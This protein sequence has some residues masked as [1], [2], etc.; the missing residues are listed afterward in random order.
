MGVVVVVDELLVGLCCLDGVQVYALDV[1]DK[2]PF[3]HGLI[4]DIVEN[5]SLDSFESRK[6][7]CPGASF[8]ADNLVAAVHAPYADGL[9]EPVSLDG[10]GQFRK[11]VFAEKL[12]GLERV[13]V[14]QVQFNF[15]NLLVIRSFALGGSYRKIFVSVMVLENV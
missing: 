4:G 5:L 14:N 15:N 12:A 13:G 11:F 7:A 6:P 3:R 9:Q 10:I 2:R 8:T 1:L